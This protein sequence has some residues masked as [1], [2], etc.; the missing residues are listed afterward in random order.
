LAVLVVR[1]LHPLTARLSPHLTLTPVAVPVTA[2]HHLALLGAAG[3]ATGLAGEICAL[4]R[5]SQLDACSACCL[6][7]FTEVSVC[8]TIVPTHRTSLSWTAHPAAS[9]DLI[10]AFLKRHL[11][12]LFIAGQRESAGHLLQFATVSIKLA[13]A[14]TDGFAD[15]L[16]TIHGAFRPVKFVQAEGRRYF[17]DVFSA[18]FP[19]HL[20]PVVVQLP[21]RPT[22]D[23]A[24]TETFVVAVLRSLAM[25][26][27]RLHHTLSTGGPLHLAGVGINISIAAANRPIP[28]CSRAVGR[29]G[30]SA[31]AASSVMSQLDAAH[32][33]LHHEVAVVDVGVPVRPAHHVRLLVAV[34]LAGRLGGVEPASLPPN[35]LNIV[36]TIDLSHLAVVPVYLAV[37]PAHRLNSFWAVVG[38][39]ECAKTYSVGANG[40]KEK[41]DELH[42]AS[43]Q[44][45]VCHLRA[46]VTLSSP[47]TRPSGSR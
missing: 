14:A 32:A 31:V 39:G 2:A 16:A 36:P 5:V 25:S 11:G 29:A 15:G 24:D 40:G 18:V 3:W 35:G 7:Q 34:V 8:D 28:L 12:N 38:T 20:A 33:V 23:L 41:D 46:P 1:H 26:T 9:L 19:H 47:L 37:L 6:L 45:P 42:D 30:P 21:I 10:E 27:V 43:L 13:I 4:A 17:V 22:T 44:P